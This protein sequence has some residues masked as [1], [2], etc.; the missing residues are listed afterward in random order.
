MKHLILA[1]VLALGFVPHILI[2]SAFTTICIIKWREH[3]STI[4]YSGPS[5][6]TSQTASN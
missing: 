2:G 1:S 6:S 3:S 4:L 5:F